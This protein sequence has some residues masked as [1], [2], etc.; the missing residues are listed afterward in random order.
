MICRKCKIDKPIDD[1]VWRDSKPI[2]L[3]KKCKQADRDH[4]KANERSVK[5]YEKK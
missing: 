1:M 3:C 4:T 5:Y 2:K